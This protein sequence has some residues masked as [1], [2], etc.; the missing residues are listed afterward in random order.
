MKINNIVSG[1]SK[2]MLNL[3]D[4]LLKR[5]SANDP[6]IFIFYKKNSLKK[7]FVK[8]NG[9]EFFFRF[10]FLQ[11]SEMYGKKIHQNGSM[12]IFLCSD[13]N[14]FVLHVSDDSK[15]KK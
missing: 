11:S 15:K 1:D 6:F 3:V 10:F 12:N 14:A 5:S 9:P 8:K 7:H 4:D 2:K 13:F